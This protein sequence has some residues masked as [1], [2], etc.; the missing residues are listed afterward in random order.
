VVPLAIM[1]QATEKFQ[2]TYIPSFP[3]DMYTER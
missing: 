2:Y 1:A 3:V